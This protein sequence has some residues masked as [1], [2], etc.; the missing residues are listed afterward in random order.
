MNQVENM[1]LEQLITLKLDLQS[2]G[3]KKL[4]NEHKNE[5]EKV[6]HQIHKLCDHEWVHDLI[7]IDPDRSK[8]ICYCKCCYMT[9]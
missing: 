8:S 7:D 1:T 6:N 4:S 9:K 2:S 3:V 5:L